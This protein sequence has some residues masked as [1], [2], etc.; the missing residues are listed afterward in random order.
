[1]REARRR[2]AEAGAASSSRSYLQG[3][4]GGRKLWGAGDGNFKTVGNY[5][6]ASVLGTTWLVIDR[7]DL[8]S[9][10]E[11][12]EGKVRVRDFVKGIALNI[13]PGKRYVAKA[14]FLRLR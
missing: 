3:R 6:S 2:Q 14:P 4:G 12:E 8:S 7:C 1:M 13:T 9:V 11:V 10:F 5:G